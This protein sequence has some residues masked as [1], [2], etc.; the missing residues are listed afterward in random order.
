MSAI[1]SSQIGVSLNEVTPVSPCVD[2]PPYLNAEV[3][4]NYSHISVPLGQLYETTIDTNL[5]MDD[6]SKSFISSY[7]VADR[8]RFCNI[9]SSLGAIVAFITT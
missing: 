3:A 2:S 5:F 4:K 1:D 7:G 6:V 8:S 9:T